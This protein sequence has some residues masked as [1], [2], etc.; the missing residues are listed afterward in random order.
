[1]AV[2]SIKDFT[3]QW[4]MVGLLFFSLISFAITFTYNNN[5]NGLGDNNQVFSTYEDNSSTILM[6]T[7]DSANAILNISSQTN[8]E[9]SDSGSRDIVATAY[10]TGSNARSNFQNFIQF[11]QWIIAGEVGKTL[12]V[13][14]GGLFALG[15]AYF[16]HKSIRQGS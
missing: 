13:T 2:D 8:P 15:L 10:K 14:I 16:I 9:I 5:P 1:M 4:I 6:E 7:K 3:V 12:A 11:F